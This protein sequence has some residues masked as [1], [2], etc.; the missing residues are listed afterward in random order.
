MEA[1]RL[2]WILA[3]LGATV[4][5]STRSA[6]YGVALN[7]RS[8]LEKL[9]P[10]MS[11]DPYKKP[12]EAPILYLRPRNTWNVAGGSVV[13][14]KEATALKI[15]GTLGVVMGRTACR[16]SAAQALDFVAGYIAV[17]DASIPH[18][19]YYRP[20]IKERCRDGFCCFGAEPLKL[21]DP[22]RVEIRVLVD[23]QLRS[24]ANTAG[25]VRPIQNLIADISEFITLR[26]GDV[27][28][29]GEPLDSPLVVAGSMTRVEIDGLPP[30]ENLVVAA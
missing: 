12:P 14:P 5:L 10:K 3:L 4:P 28:L 9:Q 11:A 8:E 22:N 20:A 23:G 6:V 30:L 13:L 27:L 24:S 1:C 15:A 17:S 16:V 21:A 25:L 29:A 26:E 7:F 2:P 19:S 18:E